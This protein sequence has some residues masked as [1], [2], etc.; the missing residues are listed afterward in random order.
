MIE[1]LI[2]ARHHLYELFLIH[3]CVG[4]K[5]DLESLN[6]FLKVMTLASG[7]SETQT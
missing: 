6:N 1:H 3:H 5:I 2:C 7:R 4:K